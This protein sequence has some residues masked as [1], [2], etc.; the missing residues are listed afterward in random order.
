MKAR[1]PTLWRRRQPRGS[2][3]VELLVALPLALLVSAAAAMLLIRLA[4]SA[5]AQSS[6]LFGMR[7]MRHA[8]LILT[9]D[10]EP[11]RGRDLVVV[12]DTV[13]EFRGQL[14]AL[15]LCDVS[16]PASVN[17]TALPGSSDVWVPALRTGD[18]L[19]LWRSAREPAA[20]PSEELRIIGAPPAALGLG[21]CG[22]DTSVHTR[23]WRLTLTDSV[24]HAMAG[25]VVSV[26]RQVRYRHYRSGGAWWLGRQSTDGVQWD[27]IQ[28]VAGPL[29]SPAQ[30][31]LQ[32]QALDAG[33]A[34]VP[35]SVATADSLRER[36]TQVAISLR[37][38]RL[39]R[40]QWS[41]LADSMNITAPLRA[42]AY[43]QR[44]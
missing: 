21:V 25:T 9:A 39:V 5:R 20:A 14:G 10:L 38:A 22:A 18:Q 28:P 4:R 11:L 36:A 15:R 23:R 8:R 29:L 7:E 44:P 13:L 41:P 1:T 32:W 33:R 42:M 16:A 3:L 17:V 43:R 31:G 6:A 12:S 35:I 34:L 2:T 37:I 40:E 30:G 19:R 26:H 27:A 24:R